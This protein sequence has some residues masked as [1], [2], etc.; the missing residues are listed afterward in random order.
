MEKQEKIIKKLDSLIELL[1]KHILMLE[2][3][4]VPVIVKSKRK[5]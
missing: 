5:K 1:S 2:E 4:L 3:E